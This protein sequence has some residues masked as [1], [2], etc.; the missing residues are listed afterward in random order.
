MRKTS[1]VFCV[2]LCALVLLGATRERDIKLFTV[3]YETP[4]GV[5]SQV[6]TT[7]SLAPSWYNTQDRDEFTKGKP[8]AGRI[9]DGDKLPEIDYLVEK[10]QSSVRVKPFD[11]RIEFQPQSE[12][13][14]TVRGQ[15]MGKELD[16]NRL[17]E[18]IQLVLQDIENGVKK[19]S[20]RGKN[21]EILARILDVPPKHEAS[22]IG[23]I[24]M[25]STY[26]TQCSQI[27]ARTANIALALSN[28]N[29]LVV[30]NGETISFNKI[31]GARSAERG[32]Q[33]AK[34]IMDGEFVPGIGGGVCQAST[35]LFN[36]ALLSGLKIEKSSNH[37]LEISYVP[38]GRDAMVSSATDLEIRNNTGST[39]YIEAGV[40]GRNVFVNI[41]GKKTPVKYKPRVEVTKI[42]DMKLEVQ[43]EDFSGNENY[44]QIIVDKGI[45]PKFT[46]TYLDAF[47]DGKLVHTYTIRKSY[48]KGDERVIRYQEKEILDKDEPSMISYSYDNN[49][50]F[51]ENYRR[52][53]RRGAPEIEVRA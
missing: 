16:V 53:Y 27:A 23:N 32:Y 8:L 1:L 18:D 14:F 33:C 46:T 52:R 19:G 20:M 21:P 41:W 40:N 50:S 38:L 6:V 12:Q 9:K 26:T 11:G 13:R 24:V 22:I 35:T 31:V 49:R 42:H 43:G 47:R 10:I 7:R 44:E 34:I 48:Y 2:V 36:A 39:L 15:R 29:G 37:S 28:F 4:S 17:R 45:A 30:Q 51:R 3:V 25:R 5:V